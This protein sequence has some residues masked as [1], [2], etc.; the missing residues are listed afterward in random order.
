MFNW[1]FNGWLIP[2]LVGSICASL[3][4]IFTKLGITNVSASLAGTIKAIITALFFI[5]FSFFYKDFK[6]LPSLFAHKKDL[7]FLLLT[8]VFG[9]FSW[10]FMNI[11]LKNTDAIKVVP[12]DK[13]SIAITVVLAVIFLKEHITI[14]IVIGV[15]LMTIGAILVSLK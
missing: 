13:L 8:G 11:A 1:L 14:K 3:V 9:G 5:L 7:V 12:I 4:A 10:F 6:E 15:I 2:A